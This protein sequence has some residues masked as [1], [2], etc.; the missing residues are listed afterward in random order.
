MKIVIRI[1]TEKGEQREEG[2]QRRKENVPF[3]L[4]IRIVYI[5]NRKGT[6][7]Y[8]Q[9]EE[10]TSSRL[11]YIGSTCGQLQHKQLEEQQN[12]ISFTKTNYTTYRNSY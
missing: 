8:F 7:V 10:E 9:N 4:N 5:E 12:Q 1:M 3:L 2:R 11:L 6:L